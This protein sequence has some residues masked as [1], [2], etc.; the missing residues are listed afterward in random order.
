MFSSKQKSIKSMF[1]SENI[2]KAEKV[3][4]KFFLYNTI[5]FNTAD[6]GPYYQAIINIIG[7]VDPG[8]KDPT[9]YQIGKQYLEKVKKIEGYIDSI[10]SKM[11]AI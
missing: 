9:G 2:K 6:S 3:I 5:P 10:K 4:L 11:T 8:V 7:E 1:S